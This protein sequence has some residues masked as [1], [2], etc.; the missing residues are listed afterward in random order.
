MSQQSVPLFSDAMPSAEATRRSRRAFAGHPS[1]HGGGLLKDPF[2][3]ALLLLVV[4]SLSRLPG[5]IFFLSAIR[6][7]MLLFLFCLGYALLHPRKLQMRNLAGSWTVRLIYAITVVACA[8]VIFGI[9]E[10]HSATFIIS[11]FSKTLAIT[12]LLILSIRDQFDLRRLYWS[13]ALGAI[14]LAFLSVFIVGISKETSGVSYDANDVGV[15]MVTSLPIVLLLLQTA[16]TRTQ[17][18]LAVIGLILLAMTIVKTQSRGAFIGT[19]VV[20]GVLLFLLPGISI[21]RRLGYV[22]VA[23]MTMLLAAPPGYWKAMQK[24][25]DDPKEDY[26]WDSINGRRNLAKRGIGYM[27]AYPVFGIGIDNFAKAEGTISDKALQA[28]GRG[29][30]WAAPHNSFVQAGAETGVLG[31]VLWCSL[32]IS[33]IILPYR[34]RRRIPKGLRQRGPPALHFLSLATVYMPIAQLG[35]AVTAFFVSFAWLE[36]LYFLS[37]IVTGTCLIAEREL[38]PFARRTVR[39][40]FQPVQPLEYDA[41]IQPLSSR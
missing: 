27:L 38:R 39:P 6:T 26:N 10:G 40:A 14:V 32:V 33:N 41:F 17:R 29:V 13:F 11:N 12:F 3:I 25:I 34:I 16:Q 1:V 15:F 31:L 30:R 22:V 23:V 37:A 36:P 2:R 18:F 28:N 35:F 9:S 24:I 5:Y 8:S 4:F 21:G 7:T 20:G 19:L